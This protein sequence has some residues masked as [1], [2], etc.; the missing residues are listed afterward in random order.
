MS[1]DTWFDDNN[2][3]LA[4]SLQWLRL[5]LQNLIPGAEPD[6]KPALPSTDASRRSWFGAKW[7]VRHPGGRRQG[8]P[9]E[10]V[11]QQCPAWL[12]APPREA[13]AKPIRSR[14]AAAGQRL[15]WSA[16]ERDTL[17]ALRCTGLVGN[18]GP[19]CCGHRGAPRAA[20]RPIACPA[21]CS[22]KPHG[23]R[24]SPHRP[25]RYARLIEINQPRGDATHRR[26]LAPTNASVN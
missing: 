13:A 16:F 25:L 2:R 26:A 15:G 24:L 14:A 7:C 17:L 9:E 22:T 4:V 19:V 10:I 6:A 18:G 23:M 12:H 3:Y 11:R 1:T 8:F 5:K 20:I 21:S